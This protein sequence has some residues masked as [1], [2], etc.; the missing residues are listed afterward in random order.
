MQSAGPNNA[1]RRRLRGFRSDACDR[2]HG[3]QTEKDLAVAEIELEQPRH[4]EPHDR[5]PGSEAP[6]AVGPLP[7]DERQAVA[8]HQEN[9]QPVGKQRDHASLGPDLNRVAVQVRDAEPGRIRQVKTG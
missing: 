5:G 3:K 2:S 6:G 9:E 4:R 8:E 7:P 1:L